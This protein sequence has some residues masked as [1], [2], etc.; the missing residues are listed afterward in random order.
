MCIYGLCSRDSER[1]PRVHSE[2]L[3][4]AL[5]AVMTAEGVYLRVRGPW[6]RSRR[7]VMIYLRV[8]GPWPCSRSVEMITLH[9]R[10]ALE[11]FTL[12]VRGTFPRSRS[13]KN[14]GISFN[15]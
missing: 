6:P 15:P 13:T 5:I 14:A 3:N 7:V 10:G 2:S 9:V 12:R 8:R 1:I 11:Y 4:D